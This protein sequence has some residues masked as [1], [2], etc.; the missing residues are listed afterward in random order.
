MC[1]IRWR[2]PVSPLTLY[3]HIISSIKW[4]SL[5]VEEEESPPHSIRSQAGDSGY[6]NG[7]REEEDLYFIIVDKMKVKLIGFW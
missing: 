4:I 7:G 2:A 6:L 3:N 1:P 5:A